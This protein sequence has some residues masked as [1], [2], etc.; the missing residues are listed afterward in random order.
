MRSSLALVALLVSSSSIAAADDE[1]ANVDAKQ[2]E[3]DGVVIG[4]IVLEKQNVFDLS[5]PQED[6]WIY[7]LANKWHVLTK[8][9]VIRK[10]LLLEPGD[11]YSKRLADETERILRGNRFLYDASVTPVNRQDDTV[12]LKVWTRDVW[13]LWPVLTVSRKGGENKTT[14]GLEDINLLG[15]GQTFRFERTEDVDRTAK[16]FEFRDDNLGSNWLSAGLLLADNSDGHSRFLSLVR[17]FY[18]LDTRWSAGVTAFDDDR[19]TAFYE[20]GDEVAEYQ[21]ARELYTA[22]GGWS[23]GLQDGWVKRFTAGVVYDE[24]IFTPVTAGSLPALVPTDRKLVY[25]FFGFELLED[26]FEKTTNK[27]QIAKTEDFFT[28][29]QF[30]ATLG[31][32]DEGLGSDRDAI[33]YSATYAKG[34]GSLESRALLVR[35]WTSGRHESGDVRNALLRVDAR[36]YWKQSEK[37]AFYTTFSG[38]HGYALDADNVVALGGDNGLR[39]YPLRYQTGDSRFLATIEQRYYTDWYPFRLLR[40]GGAIFADIGRTWGSS[41][42]GSPSDGWLRDVGI[43]LRFASTRTGGN[44]KVFHLD[45]AFPLDGDPS[46]DDVQIL[47]ESKRRF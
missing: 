38:T 43:G 24:N 21:H 10:Q 35:A 19:R 44:E 41:P 2:L 45:L 23:A 37:R 17:P 6:N 29:T 16:T 25:P 27:N 30:S 18:A 31:W 7:R 20:L 15:R 13:T 3:V 12:D 5:N 47:L 26:K 32:A 39:G 28:G 4:D 8:D 9:R 14:V 36:L 11:P 33:V 42:D 1:P 40:V 22:F 46:I 34:F